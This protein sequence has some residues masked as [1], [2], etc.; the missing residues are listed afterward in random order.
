[1][2]SRWASTGAGYGQPEQFAQDAAARLHGS[3]RAAE[4]E[5][6]T[7]IADEDIEPPLDLPQVLIELAGQV[8]ERRIVG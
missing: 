1:M 4:P 8:G 3:R 5:A 7:A 2:C 6:V